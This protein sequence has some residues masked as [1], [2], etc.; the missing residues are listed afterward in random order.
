M[1]PTDF[2]WINKRCVVRGEDFSYEATCL[3]CFPKSNGK[4][5]YIVE[6]N[7][8]LFIQRKEQITF[9]GPTQDVH[10]MRA[11]AEGISRDEAKVRN[12][13]EAYGIDPNSPLFLRAQREIAAGLKP[14]PD[15]ENHVQIMG[16]RETTHY[17]HFNGAAHFVK[18]A[19]FFEEQG[20][21]TS[22]WGKAWRPVVAISIEDARALSKIMVWPT[23]KT[24]PSYECQHGIYNK[25]TCPYCNDPLGR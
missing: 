15:E 18:E 13:G 20:G 25:G 5:R 8:R 23:K 7:G 1:T 17:V 4:V 19:K 11:D 14:A 22:D 2:I 21:L 12:Y 24:S 10:Q 16:G 3:C 6:D 9:F